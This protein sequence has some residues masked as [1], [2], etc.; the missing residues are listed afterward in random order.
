M[1]GPDVLLDSFYANLN[2]L[3]WEE[4]FTQTYGMSSAAFISEFEE[5]L[6][7]PLAEQVQILP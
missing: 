3:D 6:D 2:D 5:F 1:V 4:S 7:L